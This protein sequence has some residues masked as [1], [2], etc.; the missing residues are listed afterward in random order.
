MTAPSSSKKSFFRE[1]FLF[2]LNAQK[3]GLVMC[4]IFGMVTLPGAAFE[5]H[6]IIKNMYNDEAIP[7]DTFYDIR[8]FFFII[9]LAG[10]L[11]MSVIGAVISFLSCNRRKYTDMIG[12][13]PL[14]HKER[15]WG[16]FLSGYIS[17][18]YI[19]IRSVFIGF[20]I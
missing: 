6:D 15:F 3:F 2:R 5:L 19:F 16:D 13:L 11:I 4:T 1:Y 10:L 18:L 17:Y 9:C 20:F 12:G 8:H 14:T 7:I